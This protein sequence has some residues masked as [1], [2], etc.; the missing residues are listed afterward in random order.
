MRPEKEALV[1]EYL[2]RLNA[3]PFFIAVGYTGL[4]VAQ[5]TELRRRLTAVGAEVH[6][7]KNTIFRFAA[8]EA[9]LP[10]V[11][12]RLGGQVAVVTGQKDISATAKVVKTMRGEI[13]KP[14][15]LFGFLGD[16]AFDEAAL[17]VLADLPPLDV[18]RATLLGTLMAPASQLARLLG[19][20]AT[21]LARVLNARVDQQKAAA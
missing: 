13:E 15:L 4:N 7:V 21:Q 3:S 9:G 1:R 19:T 10:D 18:L 11:A 20:P 14:E 8:K 5:F 12:D 17:M 2:A 16:Q 6:V